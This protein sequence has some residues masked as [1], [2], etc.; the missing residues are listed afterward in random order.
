MDDAKPKQGER[1]TGPDIDRRDLRMFAFT[2]SQHHQHAG[3]EQDHEEAAHWTFKEQPL[4]KPGDPISIPLRRKRTP[5][6]A[7]DG[8]HDEDVHRENSA[9]S[10]A[11][12]HV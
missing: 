4:T 6:G 9:D 1:P 12:D 8:A 11:A 5:L 3:P 10:D 2:L 7:A